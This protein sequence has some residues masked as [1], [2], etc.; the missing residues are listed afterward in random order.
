VEAQRTQ[1][2]QQLVAREMSVAQNVMR[3]REAARRGGG[4][5]RGGGGG[6][7]GRPP[8]PLLYLLNMVNDLVQNTSAF[9]AG[10]RLFW[11]D[12]LLCLLRMHTVLL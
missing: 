2:V 12:F 4:R 1:K 11:C 9:S 6:G 10:G 7:G 8:R 5:G 3:G